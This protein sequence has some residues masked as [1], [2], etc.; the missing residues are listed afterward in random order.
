MTSGRILSALAM[1]TGQLSQEK[2]Q[3]TIY[4]GRSAPGAYN[5]RMDYD[6]D[7]AWLRLRRDNFSLPSLARGPMQ[8]PQQAVT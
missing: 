5:M 1:Q 8:G 4:F 2:A 7:R 3:F 6:K